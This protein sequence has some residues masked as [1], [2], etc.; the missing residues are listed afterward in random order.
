[1]EMPAALG[2]LGAGLL[3]HTRRPL[4]PRRLL[5][6]GGLLG[7]T[8]LVRANAAWLLVAVVLALAVG[9]RPRRPWQWVL[10]IVGFLAV[11]S[12]WLIRNQREFG[13]PFHYLPATNYYVDGPND[14]LVLRSSPPSWGEYRRAHT[15]GQMAERARHGLFVGGRQWVG[16]ERWPLF[17]LALVAVVLTAR[18]ALV[19]AVVSIA[20]AFAGVFWLTVMQ[21]ID[22]FSYPFLPLVA[23]LA[24][25]GCVALASRGRTGLVAAVA[26]AVATC[27]I[28]G[29]QVGRDLSRREDLAYEHTL[30]AMTA[31]AAATPPGTVLAERYGFPWVGN[32]E[33]QYRRPTVFL[34]PAIPF[35]P[36]LAWAR[37]LGARSLIVPDDLR[38]APGERQQVEALPLAARGPGWELHR[39]DT[40]P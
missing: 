32:R 8:Y 15:V 5:A 25:G 19:F 39:L 33:W 22:R 3:L 12:P 29:A 1:T 28:L 10:P 36:A 6:V 35:D 34:S 14:T 37:Q 21:P 9:R 13:Q 20:V 18:R 38:G 4:G 17:A 24:A 23:V 30:R 16:Q 11:A 7:A 27:A 2:I 40:A 26:A 31:A